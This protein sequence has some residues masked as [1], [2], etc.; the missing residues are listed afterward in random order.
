VER[1]PVKVVRLAGGQARTC[2]V[3]TFAGRR[4][5]EQ[6]LRDGRLVR[7]RRGVLALPELPDA[8]AVAASVGGVVS[9]ASAAALIG[10]DQVRSPQLVDVTVLR[11]RK[12]RPDSHVSLHWTRHLDDEGGVTSPLRTVLDCASTLPFAE[13]LAIADSA[14]R[15]HFVDDLV[16]PALATRGP[17]RARRLRVARAA[18]GRADN[19]MESVLRAIV[20]D[21]GLTGFVPQVQI[22]LPWRRHHADLADER[23]R[24][25]LEAD[26]YGVHG[27][28]GALVRDCE[29]DH[30]LVAAGWTLLR[31]AWEHVML[32]REQVTRVVL[33]TCAR[34]DGHRR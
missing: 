31:F 17:G 12:P 24:L 29:R 15:E 4:R 33:A 28:R 34:L 8:V 26:G 22:Q 27:G 18:D 19:P 10:L 9:H 6:A 11:G 3:V 13:A 16:G 5:L 32:R 30:E 7:V 1:D 2:E 20:L 14:L 23:R 25:V 21:A